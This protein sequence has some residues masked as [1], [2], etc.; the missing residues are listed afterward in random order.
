MSNDI[1]V[2][3]QQKSLLDKIKRQYEP[4]PMRPC[5]YEVFAKAGRK[6]D[7]PSYEWMFY[8]GMGDV[9]MHPAAPE[10]A[11]AACALIKECKLVP[12][13]EENFWGKFIRLVS[14]FDDVNFGMDDRDKVVMYDLATS[15]GFPDTV[16]DAN[17]KVAKKLT[18][19]IDFSIPHHAVKVSERPIRLRNGSVIRPIITD[20]A[21]IAIQKRQEEFKP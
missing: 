12:T 1:K 15:E 17:E 14:H 19:R 16:V 11:V 13:F 20:A 4:G 6:L 9:D 5:L 7:Q 3:V 8:A 2:Y 10:E 18:D 21:Q